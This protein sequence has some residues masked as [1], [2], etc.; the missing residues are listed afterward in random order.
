ALLEAY[1]LSSA[2]RLLQ[3]VSPSFDAFGEELFT[4]LSCGASLVIERG[5]VNYCAEELFD[6]VERQGITT[7]HIPP[8]YWQQLVDELSSS[9][10]HISRQL[11]LFI[12]GGESPSVEKLR[13]WAVLTDDRS[14]FV[15]AYGPTEATI[16]SAVYQIEMESTRINLQTRLPVGRP[17]A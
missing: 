11:R 1:E 16:T 17:I 2:D 9:S 15:N 4:T 6:L 5:V 12:T 3:F 14:R 7:L 13:Q 10:R 8:A